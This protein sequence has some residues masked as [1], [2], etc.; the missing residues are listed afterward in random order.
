M[1]LC[2][3]IE[4]ENEFI[5]ENRENVL[6]IFYEQVGKGK[7]KNNFSFSSV[8]N[9]FSVQVRKGCIIHCDIFDKGQIDKV[10]T[11]LKKFVN[12]NKLDASSLF[13]IPEIQ[14]EWFKT[15]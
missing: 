1:A 12:I 6:A 2:I 10:L 11:N 4:K 5:L 9:L 8:N 7:I 14:M 3:N 13:Q 15:R